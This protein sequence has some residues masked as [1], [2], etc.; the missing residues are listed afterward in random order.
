MTSRQFCAFFYADLGEDLFECKKC[1]RSRKQSPGTDYRNLLGHLGTK[2]AGYVE[3]CTGHEAAAASTV[4]RFGFVDDIK[5]TIYLWMR[6]IIQ[7]NLPITE[8]E[9]KLTRKVV[10][11]KPTT[12]RAMKVYLRYVAGKVDQ[13]IASEMGESFGLMFDRWTCNFLHL[14]GIFAGYVMSGVRHQRLLDLFPM[15][16]SPPRAHRVGSECVRKGLGMVRFFIGD[17][18]STNQCIATKLGVPV[19]G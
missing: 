9:N 3:G 13:T 4:N 10:T 12:V 2:H 5:L 8:V 16:D 11:M 19:I 7:C 15:D 6:W 17:N 14:L 18:C 1:G